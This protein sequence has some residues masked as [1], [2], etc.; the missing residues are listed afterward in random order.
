[1]TGAPSPLLRYLPYAYRLLFVVACLFAWMKFQ[2][3]F[4]SD[5]IAQLA[6]TEHIKNGEFAFAANGYWSPLASWLLVPFTWL[7]VDGMDAFRLMNLVLASISLHLSVKLLKQL[8]VSKPIAY[9]AACAVA[10]I[11]PFWALY[12]LTADMLFLTVLLWYLRLHVSGKFYEHPLLA[13]LS[14]ILLY[15]AKAYGLYFFIAHS[16]L[17]LL[18]REQNKRKEGLLQM[19]KAF[20]IFVPVCALWIAMIS[21]RYGHFTISESAKYNSAIADNRPLVHPCDTMGLIAP[22]PGYRYSAWEDMTRHIAVHKPVATVPVVDRLKEN[23]STFISLLNKIPRYGFWMAIVLLAITVLTK[24]FRREM[25]IPLVTLAVFSGGYLLLF[26]EERY[27]IFPSLLLYFIIAALIVQTANLI[28]S[29]YAQWLVYFLMLYVLIRPAV[30]I[31]RNTNVYEEREAYRLANTLKRL[32]QGKQCSFAS[33]NAYQ[34]APLAWHLKWKDYGGLSGY[35]TDS[36]RMLNDLN[37]YNIKYIILPRN[38]QLPEILKPV[39]TLRI[40]PIGFLNV[41]GRSE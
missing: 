22:L 3:Y 11:L 25:V 39:F 28:R 35:G 5:A 4:V 7:P 33:W 1:M 16:L 27:L 13:A 17:M 24:R 12:Y 20:L 38:Q 9:L 26:V 10:V 36:S 34:A 29:R 32:E 37:R 21:N 8:I 18:F 30:D 6:I 19:G 14:G 15:F 23:T 40:M 2:H 41:Y 31:Y